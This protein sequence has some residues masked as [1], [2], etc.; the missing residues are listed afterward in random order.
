[1]KENARVPDGHKLQGSLA[2]SG[3]TY[4]IYGAKGRLINEEAEGDYGRAGSVG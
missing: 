4:P 3:A 2:A 1:M